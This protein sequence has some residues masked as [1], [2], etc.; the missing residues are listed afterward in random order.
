MSRSLIL[1]VNPVVSPCCSAA[2][3]RISCLFGK[4][5]TGLLIARRVVQCDKP[6]Y[7]GQPRDR[8]RLP[9]SQMVTRLGERRVSF[10]ECRFDKKNVSILREPSDL[11]DVRVCKGAIDNVGAV[12]FMISFLRWPRGR[13]AAL[14]E[15]RSR[16]AT[17]IKVP[18]GAPRSVACLNARSHGLI[19]SPM[20]S[21]LLRNTLM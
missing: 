15:G 3:E 7:P 9:C 1:F 13:N 18:S 4:T 17:S 10:E 12:I 5:V 2:H 8:S 16:H 21:T 20:A 11:F 19:K 14:S 6:L